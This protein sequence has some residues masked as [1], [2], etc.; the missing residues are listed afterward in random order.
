MPGR[1]DKIREEAAALW[2]A[3]HGEPPPADAD[4]ATVLDQ[5]LGGLP[6]AP[7][8]R[9]ATPYLRPSEIVFPKRA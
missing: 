8:E 3:L 6:D 7:Y 2:Q 1:D 4:P 9:L 5:L